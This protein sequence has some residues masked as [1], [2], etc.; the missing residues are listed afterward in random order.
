MSRVLV[1]G[2]GIAGLVG[3]RVLEQAGH[4]VVVLDKGHRPGGRLATRRP[5]GSGG[6]VFDHG[7][8]FVTLREQQLAHETA[9]WRRQGWLVEWFTGSPDLG[10]PHE[11]DSGDGHVRYRG[12]PYQRGLAEA[13]AGEL[14]DVRCGIAVT[15]LGHDGD[16]W[17]A[18]ATEGAPVHADALLC[19][20][21]APQALA[22][23]VGGGVLLPGPLTAEL[24]RVAFDPCIAVLAVPTGEVDLP[25]RGRGV[26]RLPDHDALDL[27][28]DNR[29]KGIS[30]E[31]AVTIH[32]TA[33]WSRDHWDSAD[34]VVGPALVAVARDL[35]GADA[36][37][38]GVHRWRY[39]APTS[40]HEDL[41]PG[42]DVPG[43]VRFAG[44]AFAG[45]RVEGA[46]L[47]G[48]TAAIRLLSQL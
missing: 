4:T 26:V 31:P 30:G 20:P 6:P 35:L 44:D 46:A 1:L 47:S 32:A 24:E 10:A 15:A 42:G 36:D 37:V 27:V 28:A 18:S 41:A 12:A 2:A 25:D 16:Q 33:A 7:A 39:S 9:R 43:P 5:D 23:L 8:Q 29:D 3:A 17:V 45:G 48:H 34:D 14:A 13:L 21:P 40:H 38:V 19:T 22:L 11:P